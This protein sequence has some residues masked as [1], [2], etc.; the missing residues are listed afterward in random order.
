MSGIF[1]TSRA[2]R[3][4]R[5]VRSHAP[6]AALLAGGAFVGW[7]WAQPDGHSAFA[8]RVPDSAVT[9]QALLDDVGLRCDTPLQFRPS[10]N[11]DGQGASCSDNVK[12]D[13][14]VSNSIDAAYR[15]VDLAR[16]LGCMGRMGDPPVHQWFAATRATWVLFT[17][18][19]DVAKAALQVPGTA[20]V[21]GVCRQR[22]PTR[23]E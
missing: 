12:F 16:A 15:S 22:T 11:H 5:L 20:V 10:P 6:A 18:D 13:V 9:V 7:S 4:L 23:V 21:T 17:H 14:V 8:R 3:L 19:A 2:P 1:F